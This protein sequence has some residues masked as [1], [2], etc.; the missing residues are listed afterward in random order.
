MEKKKYKEEEKEV[1]VPSAH[2]PEGKGKMRK[3]SPATRSDDAIRVSAKD[4]E[5]Y[6]EILQAMNAKVTPKIRERRS[7][8]SEEPGGR[9]SFWS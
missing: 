5:S 3:R 8:P 7:S 4:G 1:P 6:A 9:R 2:D